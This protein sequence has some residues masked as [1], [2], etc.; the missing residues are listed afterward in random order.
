MKTAKCYISSGPLTQNMM[1]VARNQP[2]N[3]YIEID[4]KKSNNIK[5]ITSF[6]LFS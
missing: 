2:F 6:Q 1:G 4:N 5:I 3:Q